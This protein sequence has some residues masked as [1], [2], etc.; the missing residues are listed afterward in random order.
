[1]EGAGGCSAYRLLRSYRPGLWAWPAPCSAQS[2]TQGLYRQTL[3][4]FH[5]HGSREN[6]SLSTQ[7]F[8]QQ[9]LSLKL[10]TFLC[11]TIEPTGGNAAEGGTETWILRANVWILSPSEV[12][13]HV[14]GR[15]SRISSPSC[16]KESA[17]F[18]VFPQSSAFSL[19]LSHAIERK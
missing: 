15:H 4:V 19:V 13:C 3:Q 9:P 6:F 11:G 16:G 12:T 1:M 14:Y 8:G 7:G 2:L 5:G 18:S 10:L 17:S